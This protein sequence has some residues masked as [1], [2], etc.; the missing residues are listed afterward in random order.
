MAATK[1]REME[2]YGPI[3]ALLEGQGYEV[4]GEVGA[5]DRG[6]ARWARRNSPRSGSVQA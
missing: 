3:R 1:I 2:A 6:I 5:A 4:K